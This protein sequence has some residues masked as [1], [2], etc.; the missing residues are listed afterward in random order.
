MP[1][2]IVEYALKFSSEEEYY[3]FRDMIEALKKLGVFDF[4]KC[5]IGKKVHVRED[6]GF[7]SQVNSFPP[8]YDSTEW[9]WK[10]TTE[11]W[12]R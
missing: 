10:W 9:K 11:G 4:E 1:V 7:E 2:V 6:G 8:A 5:V 12:P 3:E